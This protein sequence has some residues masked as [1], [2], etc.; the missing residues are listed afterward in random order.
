MTELAK[1]WDSFITDDPTTRRDM[2]RIGALVLSDTFLKGLG[3]NA[4]ECVIPSDFPVVTDILRAKELLVPQELWDLPEPW[5]YEEIVSVVGEEAGRLTYKT[6]IST[7]RRQEIDSFRHEWN[8]RIDV[9]LLDHIDTFYERY[10]IKTYLRKK[11][12]SPQLEEETFERIAEN[13]FKN[14]IHGFILYVTEAAY[15]GGVSKS[16]I[17]ARM[18]E[19]FEIGGF[20]CGWIGPLPEDGGDPV[21]AVAVFHLGKQSELPVTF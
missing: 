15:L 4:E 5:P 16:P 13:T 8:R 2:E 12:A 1:I 14:N 3:A 17:F 19:S 10:D 21:K 6:G 9:P 7:Q 20:P 18:L 11:S